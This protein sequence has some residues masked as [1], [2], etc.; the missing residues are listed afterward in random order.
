ML[1]LK[2]ECLDR[3]VLFGRESLCR[4]ARK[5]VEHYNRE[6]NHQGLQGRIIDPGPE[7]DRVVGKIG[8]RERLAGMCRYYYRKAA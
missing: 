7:V 8:S 5:Y 4:A 6:R 1:S 2:S 3:L